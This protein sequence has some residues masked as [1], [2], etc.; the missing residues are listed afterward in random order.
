[1]V[2]FFALEQIAL[3]DASTTQL[4]KLHF[5][6]G[7][8]ATTIGVSFM[9]WVMRRKEAELVSWRDH[10]RKRLEEKTS[11]LNIAIAEQHSQ[12]E[13]LEASNNALVNQ[14]ED[15]VLALKLRLMTPVQAIQT[16]LNHL[17]DGSYGEL[18][19]AQREI[20]ELTVENNRDLDR[21]LMMLVALYRYQNG[22]FTIE[23]RKHKLIDLVDIK[24][25]ELL[26]AKKKN[27]ILHVEKPNAD[28]EIVCDIAETQ[29]IISHLV[30]NAIKYAR[31]SV[32]IVCEEREETATISV[33]NDGPAIDPADMDSLFKRF[34]YVSN[35]GKYSPGTGV[36][37]CLCAEIAKAHDGTL[38]CDSS[39]GKGARFTL[40]LPFGRQA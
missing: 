34:F 5:V 30:D 26:K 6:R 22:N 28:V 14:R 2:L 35:V 37:L 29:R 33:A 7:F 16:T 39:E 23:K 9:W 38:K 15:F 21:L 36:G 12:L 11:E 4:K 13:R 8:L 18:T 25:D 24:D 40:S 20:V 10:F 1:M 32:S 19:E 31:S 17:I 3:A 27:I